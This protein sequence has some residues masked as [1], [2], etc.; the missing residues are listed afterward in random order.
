[1]TQHSPLA[2]RRRALIV[3]DELIGAIGLKADM[4]TLGFDVCNLATKPTSGWE[5]RAT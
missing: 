4:P 3:D 1:M 5:R 2:H